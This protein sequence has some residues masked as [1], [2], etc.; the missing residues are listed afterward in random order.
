[1]IPGSLFQVAR[2]QSPQVA[3][4]PGRFILETHLSQGKWARTE[5]KSRVA[6][7]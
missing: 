6:Y 1:M 3:D 4:L 5:F 7:P 2:V